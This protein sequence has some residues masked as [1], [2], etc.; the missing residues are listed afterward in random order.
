MDD[1]LPT[2]HE[3]DGEHDTAMHGEHAP[4]TRAHTAKRARPTDADADGDHLRFMDAP[5]AFGSDDVNAELDVQVPCVTAPCLWPTLSNV[6]RLQG[7]LR[8]NVPLATVRNCTLHVCTLAKETYAF[9][10]C[11]RASRAPRSCRRGA[12]MH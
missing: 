6:H 2:L 8:F 7:C 12:A 1:M 11:V 3:V 5:D 9:E 4:G 10:T